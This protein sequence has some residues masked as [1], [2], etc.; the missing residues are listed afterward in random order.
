M[1]WTSNHPQRIVKTFPNVFSGLFKI[2]MWLWGFLFHEGSHA[3][4]SKL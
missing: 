3:N 4:L 1:R 2:N